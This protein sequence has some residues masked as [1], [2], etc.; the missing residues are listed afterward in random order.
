MAFIKIV[1]C[2][3]GERIPEIGKEEKMLIKINLIKKI[4]QQL[5]LIMLLKMLYYAVAI[6][7]RKNSSLVINLLGDFFAVSQYFVF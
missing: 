5:H 2:Q 6:N 1:C 7:Q 4:K 3:T